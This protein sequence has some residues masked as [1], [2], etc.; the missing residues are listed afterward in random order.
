VSNVSR[1]KADTSHRAPPVTA[2]VSSEG[3]RSTWAR[4]EGMYLLVCLGASLT[5][6]GGMY[7]QWAVL[8]GIVLALPA[9]A[10]MMKRWASRQ[11]RIDPVSLVLAAH[12]AVVALSCIWSVYR[13]ASLLELLKAVA[14]AGLFDGARHALGSREGV[15]RTAQ[16][17]FWGG[18]AL[19]AVGSVLFLLSSSGMLSSAW[20]PTLQR[21]GV[22]NAGRLGMPFAYA[23][24]LAAY[25]LLPISMGAAL[26]FS[27]PSGPRRWV[28]VAGLVLLFVG[29]ALTESRGGVLALGFVVIILPVMGFRLGLIPRGRLKAVLATYAGLV[30]TVGILSL[31]PSIRQEVILPVLSR[32]IRLPSELMNPVRT[33][34]DAG[35]RVAM[36]GD[37]LR[38]FAH[39]PVLGS[40]AGTYSSVY[41][42][43]RATMLFSSDPHS[44]AL[45]TLTELGLLGA[46]VQAAL[47]WIAAGMMV[48]RAR[49][50]GREGAL[51]LAALVG[52]GAIVLHA[53]I[54]WDF[55]FF[56][57]PVLLAV[58]GGS[59]VGA[60]H[61]VQDEDV[62]TEQS[63]AR[64][65]GVCGA[66]AVV[67][68]CAVAATAGLALSA[69]LVAGAAGRR[70]YS[71][72][73]TYLAV[74]SQMNSLDAALPFRLAGR[75]VQQASLSGG[76]PSPLD[77]DIA[78]L[79]ERSA[80]LD[81]RNAAR[82]I[83]YAR[84]LLSRGNAQAVDV[85]KSLTTLNP[86][87][88]GTWTGLGFAY[89]MLYQNDALAREALDRAYA[90]DPVYGE[91]LL[92]DGRI[93]EDAGAVDR[94]R[95]FYQKATEGDTVT[96]TA[97]LLLARLEEKQGNVPAAIR[98]L[99][100]AHGELP[101][102]AEVTRELGRLAPVVVV[103]QP[104][105]ATRIMRGGR[106]DVT[107]LVSGR[108]I[109]EAY[110]ILLAPEVGS[111][112]ALT[113]DLAASSRSYVW[114]VPDDLP[115]G[116]YRIVVA[117][118]S[119]SLMTG[120]EG[121]GLSNSASPVMTVDG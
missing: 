50:G 13:W 22:N 96:Q 82:L 15:E 52:A 63:W 93:A 1:G 60:S 71:T 49:A 48:R 9:V 56:A 112:Q 29:V 54:D 2:S 79:Y 75:M 73:S 66:V 88:P 37:A 115:A 21:L 41:M 121:D 107:W 28:Y 20:T 114:T 34:A 65:H 31:I 43:Y 120:A 98:T 83:D 12:V 89:H 97:F 78:E 57:I 111:W 110:D 35:G 40:G 109:A 119:P 26:V 17:V 46:V 55:R 91:A 64:A 86:A 99:A 24:T 27:C 3:R 58:A 104:P 45:Q 47:L 94:A 108:D 80:S 100:K 53:F 16:T 8:L 6:D 90:L 117:A 39:F 85:Y 4:V 72:G 61:D 7:S 25:L 33:T 59:A 42:Q 70:D 36:V 38:Y 102:D 87:D 18:V 76:G 11:T 77:A 69:D 105:G 106:V 67:A 81:P 19:A 32:I 118:R 23:N 10:V 74:A 68:V 101:G 14:L 51:V 92:A 103:T 44:V 5:V 113:R 95:G 84:F 30:A 116:R 62:R